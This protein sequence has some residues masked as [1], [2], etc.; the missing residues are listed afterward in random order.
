VVELERA[1]RAGRE[2]YILGIRGPE[3]EA[4]A[5]RRLKAACTFSPMPIRLRAAPTSGRP[6]A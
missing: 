1:A 6:A 2:R 5:T 4:A 3:F